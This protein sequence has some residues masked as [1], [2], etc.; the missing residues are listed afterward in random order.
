MGLYRVLT[1]G[2]LIGLYVYIYI[3][4]YVMFAHVAIVC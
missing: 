1:K 3:Y 4:T 2:L